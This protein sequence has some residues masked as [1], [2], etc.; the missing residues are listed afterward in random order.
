MFGKFSRHQVERAFRVA[1]GHIG[2][3][4]SGAKKMYLAL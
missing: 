2:S 3:F 1:K 4:Y